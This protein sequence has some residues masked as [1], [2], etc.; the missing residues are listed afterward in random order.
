MKQNRLSR[1][2]HLFGFPVNE[3]GAELERL[4]EPVVEQVR[5]IVRFSRLVQRD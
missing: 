2:Y 4:T 1:N 5:G 3:F